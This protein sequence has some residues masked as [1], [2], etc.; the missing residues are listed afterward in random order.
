MFVPN[1]KLFSQGVTEILCP[2]E[3]GQKIPKQDAPGSVYCL[4]DALKIYIVLALTGLMIFRPVWCGVALAIA[5]QGCL[6][7][8][9]ISPP[10]WS[11]LRFS[12]IYVFVCMLIS[13]F[14]SKHHCVKMQ[15]FC[16][17]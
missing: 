10:H 17:W 13:E 4:C 9:S 15:P 8:W 7:T 12:M 5:M 2:Y 11:G 1:L 3:L 16:C 14:G 6:A